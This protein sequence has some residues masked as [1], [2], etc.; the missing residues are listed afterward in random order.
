MRNEKG[1]IFWLLDSRV[2]NTVV[3]KAWLSDQ[4]QADI[5]KACDLR[6]RYSNRVSHRNWVTVGK[7]KDLMERQIHTGP[8]EAKECY[9]TYVI[10]S[11]LLVCIWLIYDTVP[12]GGIIRVEVPI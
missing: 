1:P 5:K 9:M 8:L 6:K 7:R 4:S 12:L 11:S 2:V 3:P 10:I